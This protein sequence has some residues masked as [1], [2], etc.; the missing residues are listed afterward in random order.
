MMGGQT[1]N[2]AGQH[3]D[4]IGDFGH[5]QDVKNLRDSSV[6]VNSLKEQKRRIS[7]AMKS[8]VMATPSHNYYPVA[9]TYMGRNC[10]VPQGTNYFFQKQQRIWRS[11]MKLRK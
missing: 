1:V 4:D 7:A 6:L 2:R 10:V 9:S 5:G 11:L 8:A 3:L